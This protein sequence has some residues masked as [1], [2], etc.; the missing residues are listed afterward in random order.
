LQIPHHAPANEQTIITGMQAANEWIL[1][2][3]GASNCN[4][5]ERGT[6]NM[7]TSVPV[8]EA[9]IQMQLEKLYSKR[10][11]DWS[12]VQPQNYDSASADWQSVGGP[13]KTFERR[14]ARR[15]V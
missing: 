9:P 12:C 5:I 2:S 11:I 7:G 8:I 6:V 10:L 4:K 15:A 14:N 3:F 13:S 1:K